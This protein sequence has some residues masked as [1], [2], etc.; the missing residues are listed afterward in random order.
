[1]GAKGGGDQTVTQTLDPSTQQYVEGQ[2]RPQAQ[3]AANAALNSSPGGLFAG[4]NQMM[5][6]ALQGIGGIQGMANPWM[7][8]YMQ[9]QQGL[10]GGLDFAN[11]Q[12]SGDQLNPYMN[13]YNSQ[14]VDATRDEFTRQRGLASNSANSMATGAGAF[15]GSRSAV[16]QANML[17]DVNRNETSTIA[18]LHAGGFDRMLQQLGMDK[19]RSLRAGQGGLQGMLAGLG[20]GQG[21]DMARGNALFQGGEHIRQ[22][23]ERQL[24]EPMFRQSQALNFMNQGIGPYG[25]TQTSQ[26]G[27]G[28]ALGSA[29]GGAMAGAQFGPYGA[30][31]G[32]GIGLLGGLFG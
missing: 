22:L 5:Q 27:G 2:V 23:R 25:T 1:M 14:V 7:Q 13:P 18:N 32:G 12:F 9:K 4:P 30:A 21:V 11:S 8:Q 15:G 17:G 3:N 16:L 10:A 20:Q 19:D 29:A 28:N 26:G 31:I 6:G 24:Q